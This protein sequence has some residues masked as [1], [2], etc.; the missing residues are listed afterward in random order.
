MA[1]AEQQ[2]ATPI[3]GLAVGRVVHFVPGYRKAHVAAIITHVPDPPVGAGLVQLAVFHPQN[4]ETVF[5]DSIEHDPSGEEPYTWHF[6]EY[7]P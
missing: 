6:P 1:A 5:L 3:K 2:Q 4:R 7:V